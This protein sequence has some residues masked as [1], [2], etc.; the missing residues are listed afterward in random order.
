M[1][2]CHGV[3]GGLEIKWDTLPKSVMIRC[4]FQLLWD[5]GQSSSLPFL[6]EEKIR[7]D[8]D[9]IDDTSC[10]RAAI[11]IFNAQKTDPQRSSLSGGIVQTAETLFIPVL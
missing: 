8:V 6:A 1:D 3:D 4:E 5:L 10:L 11:S 2:P 7:V 9:L